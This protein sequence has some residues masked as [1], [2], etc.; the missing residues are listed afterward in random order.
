MALKKIRLE[1][2]RTKDFPNG[3][4]THGYEIVAPLTG[5]GSLDPAEWKSQREHCRVRR[6]WEGEA[7]EVGHLVHRP[8]G[9]WAFHYDIHG[10]AST[11]EAG[12]RFS[13]ERFVP[14][15]Y[16]SI[17]E[18]DDEMRTFRVI[19]VTDLQG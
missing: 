8:G 4:R 15:E 1:L 9:S 14:G 7:D 6:F 10:D 17:M 13:A 11:D 3:S 2:A 16:V 19:T 12:Y 5:L 18:Q